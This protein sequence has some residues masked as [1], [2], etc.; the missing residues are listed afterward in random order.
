LVAGAGSSESHY[1]SQCCQQIKPD[2]RKILCNTNEDRNSQTSDDLC[3]NSD[4]N[5]PHGKSRK[6]SHTRIPNDQKLEVN[7]LYKMFEE[8]VFINERS[9][10]DD[11]MSQG[12]SNNALADRLGQLLAK[13]GIEE[14][15]QLNNNK[16]LLKICTNLMDCP[17]ANSF[18]CGLI[19]AITHYF[20][21]RDQLRLL[22]FTVWINYLYFIS[23][24]CLAVKQSYKDGLMTMLFKSFEY[25]LADPIMQT[26]KI[27]ELETMLSSFL[28]IG[29]DLERHLPDQLGDLKDLIRDA[30][31][32]NME[33]WAR[34]MLLL[35]IELA[36][37]DW[38]LCPD[39]NEHY[40]NY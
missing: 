3:S 11:F 28:N 27:Q 20:E 22:H 13:Y 38:I 26:L 14:G 16:Q 8:L 5:Y 29:R 33:P 39:A 6:I 25:M 21:C 24:M 37:N 10:I 34:K 7:N 12:M 15:R 36:S 4:F 19:T 31:I 32:S 35:L 23:E 40:F 2:T 17:S 1:V 9:L 18:H 30:F